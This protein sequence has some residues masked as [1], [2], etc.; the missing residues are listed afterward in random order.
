MKSVFLKAAALTALTLALSPAFAQ[1]EADAVAAQPS[2]VTGYLVPESSVERPGDLGVRAHTNF[3]VSMQRPAAAS[4]AQRSVFGG[5]GTSGGLGP[6]G[7]MTPAQ[8]RSFYGLPATGGSNVIAIVIAYH[9]ANALNDFNVFCTQFGLPK[10][11]SANVLASTNTVLQVVYANGSQPPANNGW[12]QEAA[13]DIEWS[14]SLAP[15]AKI[16]LIETKSNSYVDLLAGVDKALTIPGV[17]Q[18]SMS[19][20]GGEFSGETSLDY[21]FPQNAGVMFMAS[22]GDS[23][24]VVSFPSVS[25][26]VV[27]VGG[28][29][30]NTTATGVF[31]SETGWNGSGGGT[32]LYFAKP[33]YQNG[34]PNTPGNKRGVPDIS[35][36]AD[37]YTGVSVYCTAGLSGWVVFGG[38]SVACPC[39]AGMLNLAGNR[40]NSSVGLLGGIYYAIGTTYLRDITSGTAGSFSCLPGWDFVTGAGSARGSSAP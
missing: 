4:A 14:H 26:N 13:L 27:A 10:E 12:N 35:A 23:G 3:L 2:E 37:P 36:I 30:I 28:T 18:V 22:S 5:A 20:G 38:T 1:R 29:R 9:Y 8:V 11:T 15:N 33:S 31:V 19:W 24:G 7:G 25:P 6:G 40:Y 39:M 16:V 32:S 17:K 21:H 34:V